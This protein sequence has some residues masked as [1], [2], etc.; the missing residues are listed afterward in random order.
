[1]ETKLLAL[2]HLKKIRDELSQLIQLQED[3]GSYSQNKIDLITRTV[4]ECFG[5]EKS[6]LSRPSRR[7]EYVVPRQI[8]MALLS[9]HTNLST[10]KLGEMFGK[11]DHT[12][13][14]HSRKTVKNLCQTDE[15]YKETFDLLERKIQ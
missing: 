12:T 14:I 4:C 3:S 13:V 11:R 8:A 1:M 9:K 15:K 7:R 5:I 2:E 10:V 6:D